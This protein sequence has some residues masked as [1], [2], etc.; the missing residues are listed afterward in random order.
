MGQR[1]DRD[2]W[3][4][5]ALNQG[6]RDRARFS[7]VVHAAHD[8]Q[9][10][11]DHRAGTLAPNPA[12]ITLLLDMHSLE[13]PE[14]DA[15]CGA[16]EPAVD[17]WE[18]GLLIPSWEQVVLLARLVGVQPAFLYRDDIPDMGD[19]WIC[20]RDGCVTLPLPPETVGTLF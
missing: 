13:G 10:E 14:V 18:A 20:G 12:R 16:V 3:R 9:L 19:G 11:A 4:N 2:R 6:R 8:A 7:A 5:A 1:F 17:L 15:A